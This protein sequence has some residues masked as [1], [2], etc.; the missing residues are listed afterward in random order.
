MHYPAAPLK[1]GCL[2]IEK[3]KHIDERVIPALRQADLD[4]ICLQEVPQDKVGYL[5]STL[6]AT[7]LFLG[8]TLRVDPAT[9][10][11][12]LF[13]LAI[14]VRRATV[15]SCD[16]YVY[17][18]ASPA[19]LP[20]PATR[21][22]LYAVIKKDGVAYHIGDTHFTWTPDGEPDDQQFIDMNALFGV[23][24]DHVGDKLILCGDFNAPRGKATWGMLAGRYRDNIPELI[25]TTLDQKHHRAAPIFFVVDGMFTSPHYVASEL[26]VRDNVSDHMLITGKIACVA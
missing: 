26:A 17:H 20:L 19:D 21:A 11:P 8:T 24:D 16:T 3:Y 25:E 18:E 2:N 10:A 23:I 6:G 7:A 4:V 14:L 13:G 1:L 22:L 9:N 5:E 15:V 12:H